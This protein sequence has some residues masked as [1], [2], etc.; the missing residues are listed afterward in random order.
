[1][2]YMVIMVMKSLAKIYNKCNIVMF[3]PVTYEEALRFPI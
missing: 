2:K 1:M 3:E